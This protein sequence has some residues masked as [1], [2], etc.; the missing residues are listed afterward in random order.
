M[1]PLIATDLVKFETSILLIIKCM[2]GFMIS[3][4]FH[5]KNQARCAYK[6]Y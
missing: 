5:L 3:L 4:I 6:T 1:N 2:A